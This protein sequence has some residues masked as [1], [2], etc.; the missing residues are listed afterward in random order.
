M[1]FLFTN[2]YEKRKPHSD[3]GVNSGYDLV[4]RS[5]RGLHC[6]WLVPSTGA[7]SDDVDD[8]DTREWI[9]LKGGVD[10]GRCGLV[11]LRGQR[12]MLYGVEA[13]LM[14]LDSFRLPNCARNSHISLGWSEAQQATEVLG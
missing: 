14:C 11:G 8:S 4:F 12:I 9:H 2:T 3:Q 5:V 10:R 1:A 6:T 13:A 7:S